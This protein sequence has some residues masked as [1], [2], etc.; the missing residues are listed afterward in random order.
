MTF[1]PPSTSPAQG[2]TTLASLESQWRA[3]NAAAESVLVLA[4]SA[5]G[6][7]TPTVNPAELRHFPTAVA[8]LTGGRRRLVEDG[9]ADLIAI[10]EP[11]LAALLAVHERGAS[12]V[13]PAKTLWHEFV[14]ARAMLVAVAFDRA[15]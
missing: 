8:A 7:V 3:L 5:G 14:A 6:S 11:G 10:M 4:G 13:V 2:G 15:F 1:R 9:L 12:A